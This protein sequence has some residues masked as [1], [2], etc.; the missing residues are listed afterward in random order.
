MDAAHDVIYDDA[1]L[2]HILERLTDIRSLARSSCACKVWRA[3]AACCWSAA[4]SRCFGQHSTCWARRLEPAADDHTRVKLRLQAATARRRGLCY[5]RLLPFNLK[6]TPED[7]PFF[8]SAITVDGFLL[9]TGDF[10]GAASLWDLRSG[11]QR[12]RLLGRG[13]GGVCDLHLDGVAQLLAIATSCP[14]SHL[15]D[16]SAAP[17]FA[18]LASVVRLS[19]GESLLEIPHDRSTLGHAAAACGATLGAGLCTIRRVH[20]YTEARLVSPPP[21][22]M[23]WRLAIVLSFD[24]QRDEQDDG[25][26]PSRP[27][28]LVWGAA[29]T[30]EAV[31]PDLTGEEAAVASGWAS[32][33]LG[34]REGSSVEGAAAPEGGGAR[35]PVQLL[36]V[37]QQESWVSEQAGVFVEVTVVDGGLAVTLLDVFTVCPLARAELWPV[38]GEHGDQGEPGEPVISE[39]C[40]ASLQWRSL[41]ECWLLVEVA[42]VQP[43]FHR[44][45]QKT[46]LL[47]SLELFQSVAELRAAPHHQVETGP[48]S[49]VPMGCRWH[50]EAR[51]PLL[52]LP[53]SWPQVLSRRCFP[54]WWAFDGHRCDNLAVR[55]GG[56]HG[57]A[58]GNSFEEDRGGVLLLDLLWERTNRRRQDPVSRKNDIQSYALAHFVQGVL[59]LPGSFLMTLDVQQLWEAGDDEPSAC[60]LLMDYK[61]FLEDVGL[62]SWSPSP[63]HDTV[64]SGYVPVCAWPSRRELRALA[65]E[66]PQPLKIAAQ[67]EIEHALAQSEMGDEGEARC[68]MLVASTWRFTVVADDRG[69]NIFDWLPRCSH[70]LASI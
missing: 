60:A 66:T 10:S 23:P 57:G 33:T 29:S 47:F 36:W 35:T 39:V 42:E 69:V 7:S 46:I 11:C 59:Q 63:A 17:A 44:Q 55:F 34:R 61:P 19:D 13:S 65:P 45:D 41:T 50:L 62:L 48:S 6:D 51:M 4:H 28:C 58:G 32:A 12:W 9:A 3:A 52:M 18:G 37:S 22:P 56:W 14:T 49:S 40:M 38:S 8:A 24:A 43:G 70:K 26:T 68:E 31:A 30:K 21:A 25:G 1:L 2:P 16:P 54:E 5:Q 27:T 64:N 53:A 20:V 67:S 15:H